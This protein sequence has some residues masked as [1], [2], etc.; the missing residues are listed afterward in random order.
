MRE[1]RYIIP[2]MADCYP[3][4]YSQVDYSKPRAVVSCKHYGIETMG[5]R[6]KQCHN[7]FPL[8]G[9]IVVI[10]RTKEELAEKGGGP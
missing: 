7:E 10:M 9:H 2:M 4:H 1:D 8:G 5:A 3:C 6:C